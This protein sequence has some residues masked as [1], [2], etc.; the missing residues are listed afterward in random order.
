MHSLVGA[1]RYIWKLSQISHYLNMGQGAERRVRKQ[2]QIKPPP[3]E[4]GTV[5]V[6]KM[7]GA[8]S[9]L[10]LLGSSFASPTFVQSIAVLWAACH[11]LLPLAQ[12]IALLCVYTQLKNV[13]KTFSL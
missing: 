12:E 1:L 5:T 13:G 2:Q 7:H 10:G 6:R 4:E 3:Q 11:H 8:S 9:L